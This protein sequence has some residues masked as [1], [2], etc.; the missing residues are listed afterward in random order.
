MY[1]VNA[2]G[3]QINAIHNE[4]SVFHILLNTF[5]MSFRWHD[6]N[7]V[8]YSFEVQSEN[9]KHKTMENSKVIHHFHS[10]VA[11]ASCGSCIIIFTFTSIAQTIQFIA[12][13]QLCFMILHTCLRAPHLSSRLLFYE[14][15]FG[16]H[17]S[18]ALFVHIFI[19]LLIAT[20]LLCHLDIIL[21]DFIVFQ[22]QGSCTKYAHPCKHTYTILHTQ[23]RFPFFWFYL[24]ETVLNT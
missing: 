2:C 1:H 15:Q 23:E 14:F 10:Y 5:K 9:I 22:N 12:F 17:L 6:K 24:L 4:T 20:V 21:R 8:K 7:S 11:V 3:V 16:Y 19:C 18:G 13:L